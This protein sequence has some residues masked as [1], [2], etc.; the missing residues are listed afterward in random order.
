MQGSIKIKAGKKKLTDITTL[1]GVEK[2]IKKNRA[3]M[4]EEKREQEREWIYS[5]MLQHS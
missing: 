4:A 1:S 2:S 3:S 5:P